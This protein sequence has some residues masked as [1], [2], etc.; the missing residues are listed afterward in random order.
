LLL[1]IAQAAGREGI[2]IVSCYLLVFVCGIVLSWVFTRWLRNYANTH[3]WVA[4]PELDRHVHTTSVPRIGGIAIFV[5]FT[6]VAGLAMLLPR[7]TGITLVVPVRTL[8]SIMGAAFIVFLLGL[9]DDFR[10]VGPYWKFGIQAVAAVLLYA[11][12]VGIHRLDLLSAGQAL[13]TVVGLP[14]TVLW[15]LLITNAFNLIDGLDGLAAGSALF[16]TFVVFV[17]SLVAP[18]AMTTLLAIA[19]AGAILGF[20]RFNF[21]PAS[22]FL[23]DSGS[24][25]IG[26][27]L[28]AL[29]LAGSEKAPTMIAVAIPVVSFGLPILDVALAVSRRFL[30]GKPLFR[31]DRDHIHHKLLNRGLSQRDAVLVLYGVTACF[32]LLS[33]VLLHDAAMIALVLAMIGIGIALGVQYL[34]YVELSELHDVWRRTAER[35]RVIANNVEVRRAV[36]ALNSCTDFLRMCAILQNTLRSIGFDGFRLG[37]SLSETF[38]GTRF[39]PMQR[40]TEG[41]LQLFWDAAENS[42]SVWELKLE[43]NTV[44]NHRLG[45]LSLLRRA[46]ESPLLVDLNLLSCEFRSA[47]SEAVLR[48][49]NGHRSS[50][51]R[52]APGNGAAAVAKVASAG[53]SD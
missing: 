49:M 45:R 31:G 19:L 21:H 38:S 34:G 50:V 52:A 16:S 18:N 36:D 15:V 35:K 30:S 28:A 2:V 23:G 9:Y 14:L 53:S 12:G 46:V 11:G 24:M 7:W 4:A 20:L 39:S 32:A 1:A 5:S 41:E 43:L 40:T 33:L 48:A 27:M 51:R 29:A 22:I 10:F 25:F 17:T 3:G 13:R 6:L 44:P 47:L 26:F 37:G 8:F 42:E